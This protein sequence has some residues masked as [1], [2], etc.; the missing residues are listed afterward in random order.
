MKCCEKA[1]AEY[2]SFDF[3]V[4]GKSKPYIKRVAM[5]LVNTN[6]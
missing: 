5:T 2:S 1:R 6:M 3:Y 4:A